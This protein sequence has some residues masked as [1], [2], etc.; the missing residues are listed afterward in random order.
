MLTEITIFKCKKKNSKNEFHAQYGLHDTVLTQKLMFTEQNGEIMKIL[1]NRNYHWVVI[2]NISCSKNE[3]NYNSLFHGKI[4]K[5]KDYV[6]MQFSA[7]LNALV[8]S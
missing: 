2:Y 7:F 5:I 4:N 1:H 3:I 6:K 8:K